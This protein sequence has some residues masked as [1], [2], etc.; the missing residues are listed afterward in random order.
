MHQASGTGARST[1]RRESLD[2]KGLFT[3]EGARLQGDR[4]EPEPIEE[5]DAHDEIAPPR[6]RLGDSCAPAPRSLSSETDGRRAMTAEDESGVLSLRPPDPD[7]RRQEL[8]GA[9]RWPWL[10]EH[11]SIEASDLRLA[12]S[13]GGDD[14]SGAFF[15]M[16]ESDPMRLE[17]DRLS[18]GFEDTY[19]HALGDVSSVQDLIVA[20]GAEGSPALGAVQSAPIE[21]S[22][23]SVERPELEWEELPDE[24]ADPAIDAKTPTGRPMPPLPRPGEILAI[25]N[26]SAQMATPARIGRGRLVASRLTWKPGDPFADGKPAEGRPRFKWWLMLACAG[27]T[28]VV[29]MGTIW[30]I[31][32]FL[33]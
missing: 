9:D 25:A 16:T 1:W 30:V 27:G 28:V 15:P 8:G 19:G 14:A 13:P 2:E 32:R 33:A 3:H 11:E 17:S 7:S 29:G 21:V 20:T 23:P 31:N 6:E 22:G 10:E 5:L 26:G 12:H 24:R 4:R 18:D